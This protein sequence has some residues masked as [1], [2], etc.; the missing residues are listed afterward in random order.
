MS[1]VSRL[2]SRPVLLIAALLAQA[3]APPS[4]GFDLARVGRKDR[5]AATARC[6]A[7]G[8]DEVVV[9]ARRAERDRL[10]LPVAPPVDR[11]PA[12]SATAAITSGGQ[13]GLF[14][15]ERR[16]GKAEAAGYGYGEGRDPLTA[17]GRMADALAGGD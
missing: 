3:A 6:G 14:E 2:R 13:C 17:L 15:G 10:P 16:C 4:D 7:G 12:R 8:A 5:L 11:S 1:V 9:C